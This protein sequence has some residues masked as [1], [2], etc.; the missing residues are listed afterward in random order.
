MPKSLPGFP[1]EIK[2][3]PVHHALLCYAEWCCD[4]ARQWPKLACVAY[5]LARDIS[6]IQTAFRDLETWGLISTRNTHTGQGRIVRLGDGRET[7]E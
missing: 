6:D 7:T 4:N 5:D 3:R 1:R 2:F